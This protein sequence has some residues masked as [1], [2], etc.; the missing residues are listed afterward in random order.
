MMEDS[1]LTLSPGPCPFQSTAMSKAENWEAR[2]GEVVS[3]SGISLY[4]TLIFVV[5]RGNTSAFH[6]P[7]G[8]NVVSLPFFSDGSLQSD[9]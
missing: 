3:P 7:S 4:A 5:D 1:G 2:P 9:V 6:N 8:W